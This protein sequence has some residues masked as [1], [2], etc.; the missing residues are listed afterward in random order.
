MSSDD[1][2]SIKGKVA[3]ITGGSRGIGLMIAREYVKR[4]ARVYIS[5]RKAHVCDAVAK[6]LSSTGTCF[7]LPADIS[8]LPGI[9]ALAEALAKKE[10]CLD[11]LVNNAGAAWGMPYDTFSESGWDKV[12]NLNLKSVFF[13]TQQLTPL[14]RRAAEAARPHGAHAS[15][16]NIASVDGVEAQH[17]VVETYPYSA[18]KAGL[19]HMTAVL[20]RRLAGEN[21]H[22][23]AISPGAFPS[24]MNQA[25]RD[26][27]KAMGKQIP[28]GR[29]GRGEEMAGPAVFLASRAGGYSVGAN[30]VVGGGIAMC[31]TQKYLN[32]KPKL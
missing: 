30:L 15:V 19:I 24:A 1:I 3:L 25:A 10:D 17:I 23:N 11:I 4:G 31:G 14:L 32:V 26:N 12:M 21:I 8:T 2:F 28:V 27:P 7:S 13:V 9:R 22:V 6:K 20:A 18:S 16:I 29:V 5:S